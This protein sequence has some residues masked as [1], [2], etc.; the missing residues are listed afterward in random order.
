MRSVLLLQTTAWALLFCFDFIL[1]R[2][3]DPSG[4]LGGAVFTSLSFAIVGF[5]VS[6]PLLWLYRAD[7]PVRG[8]ALGALVLLSTTLSTA[9]WFLSLNGLTRLMRPEEDNGLV[10]GLFGQ[11]MLC[12]F[13]MMAWHGALFAVRASSQAADAQ[14]LAQEARMM[15]LRYQLN[16]H[17]LF[18]VLNSAIAL[19]DENPKRAQHMLTLL[20]RLLRD[21]LD[22]GSEELSSLD[23]EM[24]IID[25]YIEIQQVRFEDKLS[26]EMDIE[27]E[28]RQCAIPPLLLHTLI[29]NAVKHGFET[30]T[31]MPLKVRMRARYEDKSLLVEVSNT[32][33]ITPQE[34]GLGLKNLGE[35]L[36]AQYPGGHS[37]DLAE[38]EGIVLATMKSESPR[39]IK[40]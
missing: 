9:V 22:G 7:K 17:F 1:G 20:S 33:C 3:A 5:A 11:G 38:S 29:E 34:A 6:T 2:A 23:K 14:R 40:R 16:P 10:E 28:A 30:A 13:V 4:P 8:M 35:R 12:F 36:Q 32:G 19:V 18:N 15:A 37:F 31:T 24:E 27:A 25:R 39:M 26:V 21:T